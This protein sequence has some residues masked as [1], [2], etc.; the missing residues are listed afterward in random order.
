M[1]TL[2]AGLSVSTNSVLIIGEGQRARMCAH[3]L[4]QRGRGR[5]VLAGVIPPDEAR[6]VLLQRG[7]SVLA[8]VA[9]GRVPGKIVIASRDAEAIP[10]DL[11][12]A[13]RFAGVEVQDATAFVEDFTGQV[14]VRSLVPSE[15]VFAPGFRISRPA[16]AVKTVIEWL[17][18]CVLLA[19]A[20]PLIGLAALAILLTDGQPIFF[21]Q[22]RIGLGGREF[23]LVKMRTMRKDAERHGPA[24]CAEGD[25]RITAVGQV[26]RRLRIDELPQL[27]NVLRGEMSLV[28]PRPEQPA[29]VREFHQLS[30]YYTLRHCFRPGI[31]G[32]A[33]VN[34][35]YADNA[36]DTLEKLSYDLFYIKNFSLA[37]DLRIWALTAWVVLTARGR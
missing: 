5:F 33:Q 27:F 36:E 23:R 3:T 20:L 2:Q 10:S 32:W 25:S 35:G 19:L 28:G 29:F 15:L 8:G 12:V 14:P 26:L 9:D 21:R 17:I 37:L 18:A 11:L 16:L 4:V 7:S 31:T 1:H 34:F 6:S 22:T 30:P 13:L 24:F